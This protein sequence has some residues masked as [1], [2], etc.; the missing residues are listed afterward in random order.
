MELSENGCLTI[1]LTERDLQQFGLRFEDLD[2]AKPATRTAVQNMLAA[3]R[4]ELGFDSSGSLLIEALPA[5]SGCILLVTPTG[6][7]RRI[8]MKRA[9][10]P[11]IYFLSDEEAL[12]QLAAAWRRI[13]GSSFDENP[14][15]ESSLYAFGNG[16][17]LVVRSLPLEG[18]TLLQE[19][20]KLV[21]E[22]DAAAA[23]TAEHGAALAEGDALPKLCAALK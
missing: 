20:G 19:C 5:A 12:F 11:F 4:R 7:H 9:A 14:E 22:G 21:G 18:A 16:Y 10:G 17:R 8:R 15:S 3:A 23:F 6:P 13:F 2:Y 1:M